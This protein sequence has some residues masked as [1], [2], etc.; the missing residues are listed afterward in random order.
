MYIQETRVSKLRLNVIF[1]FLL[2][3]NVELPDESLIKQIL[4][5]LKVFNHAII[6]QF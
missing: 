1:P 4:H 5:L 3:Q 2:E 6:F